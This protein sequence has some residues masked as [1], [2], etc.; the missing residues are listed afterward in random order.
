MAGPDWFNVLS[1]AAMPEFNFGLS[2][3]GWDII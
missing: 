1:A 2:L 3:R